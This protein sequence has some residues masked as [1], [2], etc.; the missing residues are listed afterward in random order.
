MPISPGY[1][2]TKVDGSE[3]RLY[4]QFCYQKGAFTNPD[5]TF[6]DMIESSVH[7]MTTSLGFSKSEARKLSE[8]VIPRLG[9]WKK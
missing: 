4:C 1:F 8:E 2:G 6:D 3:E 7:F 5:Q 9:R